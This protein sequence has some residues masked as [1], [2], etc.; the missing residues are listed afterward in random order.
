MPARMPGVSLTGRRLSHYAVGDEI[1]HGGMGV[2]YRATDTRLGRDVALKVLSPDVGGTPEAHK[3]FIREARAASALEHP[4]IAAIHDIGEDDGISFIAMELVHGQSLDLLVARGPIPPSRALELAIEVAEALAHAH[5]HGVIHRDVKPANVMVTSEGHVKMID[6]GLAKLAAGEASAD[7]RSTLVTAAGVVMGTMS[8][9]SPEQ[10][11]AEPVDARSDIFSFGVMLYEL[12]AGVLPFRGQSSLEI[13]DSVLR[14]PTPALPIKGLAPGDLASVELNRIVAKCL[15]KDAT[16]RYQS[17]ADLL[18]DLRAA[19]RRLESGV[20]P[21][22]AGAAATA[23][24]AAWPRQRVTMA[25]AA[26]ALLLAIAG[27]WLWQRQ[28]EPDT[29]VSVGGDRPSM[30]VMYFENNTGESSLDWLRIGLTDMLVTDLSQSPD[31]DVLSTDRL[32]QILRDMKRGDDRVISADV[33]QEVARRARVQTVLVG[34]FVKAGDAI[35]INLKVQDAGSG[36]IVASERG[37]AQTE[38]ALFPT[39]DDLTRRLKARFMRPAVAATPILN[40]PGATS[41]GGTGPFDKDLKD[42]TTA[43]IEAYRLYAEGNALHYQLREEEALPFLQKAVAVDPAF[44]LAHAKMAVIAGNLGRSR[45]RSEHAARALQHL[46]R[47]TEQERLYIQA[48]AA[49]GSPTTMQEAIDTYERVVARYPRHG[50]SR[51]NVAALYALREQFDDAIRHYRALFDGGYE[52][53]GVASGLALSYLSLGRGPEALAVYDEFMARSPAAPQGPSGRGFALLWVGRYDEARAA[54]DRALALRPGHLAAEQ[55]RAAAALLADQWEAA[56]TEL[57]AMQASDSAGTRASGMKLQAL[58]ALFRGR[59]AEALRLFERTAALEGGASGSDESSTTRALMATVLLDRGQTRE[60]LAMAERGVAEA[61]GGGSAFANTGLA[62][63]AAE[64]LGQPAVAARGFAALEEWFTQVRSPR[65]Q[66]LTALARGRVALDAGDLNRAVAELERADASTPPGGTPFLFWGTPE[67]QP[68]VWSA[69]G[70]AHLRAGRLDQA[71]Q[72]FE[73]VADSGARH[74]L[75]P[76]VY[77]ESLYQLGH[78]AERQGDSVKAR[79][80]YTRFLSYWKDGD[81]RRDWVAEAQR[82]TAAH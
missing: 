75:A 27:A 4:H 35:R 68:Q 80:H 71:R 43:S 16:A 66:R 57:R 73:R 11:R 8:Y 56:S 49:S 9:V 53:P 46:D 17:M 26:A 78:I 55:G 40:R 20:L 22:P 6:F 72:N 21:P 12:L 62:A 5:A 65:L 28:R 82:K 15:E 2:V 25:F 70:T 39:M 33:L 30:A 41:A 13:L 61:R 63:I 18:V 58:A 54:F 23:P 60:A 45:E 77:V 64:R 59:S 19:R 32:A 3:R 76:V 52:F 44:A 10:A 36:R 79:E 29:A 67:L 51:N 14:A 7:T 42:V 31:V 74:L 38:A 34:S 50:A 48:Y 37:D 1:S 47:L 81:L 24:P 69:L